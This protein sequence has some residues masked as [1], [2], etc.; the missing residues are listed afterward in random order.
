MID[1][2]KRV[3]IAP[4]RT[5]GATEILDLATV[6][7]E[8]ETKLLDLGDAAALQAHL[9]ELCA[10]PPERGE[11]TPDLTHTLVITPGPNL[12]QTGAIAAAPNVTQTVVIAPPPNLAETCVIAPGGA[13]LDR[14]MYDGGAL[15]DYARMLV[16]GQRE[17]CAVP[18]TEPGPGALRESVKSRSRAW[19][20]VSARGA[21][22]ARW[23]SARMHWRA[24]RGHWNAARPSRKLV[25]ALLPLALVA[26]AAGTIVTLTRQPLPAISEPQ[27]TAVMPHHPL[28]SAPA[29]TAPPPSTPALVQAPLP[30]PAASALQHAA[31]TAA[32]VADPVLERAA[33]RA[34]FDGN[35]REAIAAYERLA[36]RPGGEPFKL[37]ARLLRE[38]RVR[39][40]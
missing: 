33:L 20:A 14:T 35:K 40:P 19:A 37:A 29:R 22:G 17:A 18:T 12:A 25:L 32:T 36:E 30:T 21:M 2:T 16:E 23:A 4:K 38:D 3:R 13:E 28:P 10:P 15:R 39:K 9:R 6:R 7:G 8:L 26:S 24:A 27:P 5:G 34:A 1:L 11:P 31:E